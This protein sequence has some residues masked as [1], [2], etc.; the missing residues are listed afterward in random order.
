MIST[1]RPAI[2]PLCCASHPFIAASTIGPAEAA[3]PVYEYTMPILSGGE[4]APAPTADSE[5][6]PASAGI[7][8]FRNSVI[9]SP[10]E[11]I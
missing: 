11:T 8:I 5:K 4:S 10:R 6:S 7:N 3:E 2:I 9:S 1:L